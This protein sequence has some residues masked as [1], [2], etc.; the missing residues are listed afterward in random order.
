MPA[1]KEQE[2]RRVTFEHP[3]PAQMMAIDGTWRR[4]CTLKDVSD[5][6]A[7][8]QVLTSIEGLALNEFFL[9]L[10]STGLAYRRCQ[11]DR[12]NGE[13]LQVSFIRQKAKAKRSSDRS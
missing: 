12:V 9:L 10:S 13:E 4:A 11:L 2:G 7:K 5:V 6:G 1:E 8:L 3:L